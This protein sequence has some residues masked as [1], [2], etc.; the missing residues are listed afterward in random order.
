MDIVRIRHRGTDGRW[1]WLHMNMGIQ[2]SWG[3]R[4]NATTF[5]LKNKLAL[6]RA[7][8]ILNEHGWGRDKIEIVPGVLR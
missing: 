4:S 6:T 3:C 2:V 1:Q 7:L 5:E 8:D